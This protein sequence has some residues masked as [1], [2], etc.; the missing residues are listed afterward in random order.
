MIAATKPARARP[1][2][3]ESRRAAIVETTTQAI[4]RLDRMPST[5]EIAQAAGIA[6]GTIYRVFDSKDDLREAVVQRV[7]DPVPFFEQVTAV[8]T[9]QPLRDKLVEVVGLLQRRLSST[10]V[11][12]RALGLMG[13]PPGAAGGPDDEVRTRTNDVLIAL[14]RDHASELTV[15]PAELA[16]A[17]RLFSFSAIHPMISQGAPLRPEQVVDL[18]L[19]GALDRSRPA[20]REVD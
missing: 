7:F 1:L 13:P 6:E 14:V 17:L 15:T 16:H 2:T 18:L 19:Y 4:A 5:R 9:S 8:D 11:L 20:D 10:F 3:P 12:M